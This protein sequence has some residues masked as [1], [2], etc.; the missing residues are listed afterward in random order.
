MIQGTPREP[1]AAGN[2]PRHPATS[3]FDFAPGFVPLV[4]ASFSG[5]GADAAPARRALEAPRAAPAPLSQPAPSLLPPLPFQR[6]PQLLPSLPAA[7]RAPCA[8]FLGK[9]RLLLLPGNPRVDFTAMCTRNVQWSSPGSGGRAGN[10][11][12]PF[13]SGCP[14]PVGNR[15]RQLQPQQNHPK[16]LLRSEQRMCSC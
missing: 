15:I 2:I 6:S 5:G 16:A 7:L 14:P 11:P 4:F 10:P 13:S 12:C 3:V 8:P 1:T 9:E